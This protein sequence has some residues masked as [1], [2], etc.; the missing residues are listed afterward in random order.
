ML[1]FVL[2]ENMRQRLAS[3]IENYNSGRVD[4]IDFVQVG[5]TNGLPLAT[6]DSEI[7]RWAEREDRIL[8]SFDRGTLPTVLQ[9]HL[10]AGHHCPGILILRP[11]RTMREIVD[12]LALVAFAS[13]TWE[14]RDRIVHIPT[15]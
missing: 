15:G 8:V 1:A 10:D 13:E 11:G 2:D 12:F 4:S 7:L 5:D 14:W 3:A 9:N 6:P